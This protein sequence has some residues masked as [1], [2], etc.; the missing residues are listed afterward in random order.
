MELNIGVIGATGR[1]GGLI[2]KE[3]IGRGLSV[4]AIVR[5]A[6]K[7]EEGI[8]TL[9]SDLFDLSAEDLSIF[10]IVVDAFRADEG[11][12][13][14]HLTSLI[15]LIEL[16]EG[17]ETR[18]M[19]VGGAGS[20]YVDPE[21][22][23]QLYQTPDFPPQFLPTAR[24]M[25]EGLKRLQ[26]SN[27]LHWNYLSPA[28]NFIPDGERTGYYRLGAEHLIFNHSGRSEISYVDYAIAFVDEM[29]HNRHPNQRISVVWA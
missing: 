25:A 2:V 15:H 17:S 4:T 10:D 3:A 12:E 26:E 23:T 18:L 1:A 9:E 21:E 22:R 27:S 28:A 24:A 13:E 19:V 14:E 29:I 8:P 6:S 5:S 7:V 11:R 20:L 16:L